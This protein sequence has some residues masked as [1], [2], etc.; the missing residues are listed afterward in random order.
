MTR[1][2]G[3]SGILWITPQTAKATNSKS[4]ENRI[5]TGHP[6]PVHRWLGHFPSHSLH[7]QCDRR[8]LT[9]EQLKLALGLT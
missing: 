1:E 7:E 8:A 2:K 4:V 5:T 6:A 9:R 3:A